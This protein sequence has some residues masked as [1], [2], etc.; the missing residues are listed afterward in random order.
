MK[1]LFIVHGNVQGVGYRWFV[2]KIAFRNNVKGSVRNMEDGSV[3]IIAM[4]EKEAMEKFEKGIKVDSTNGPS[5]M[6]I[7]KYPES[8]EEFTECADYG[9][10]KIEK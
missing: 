4:A 10:F 8:S 1:M 2:K 9:D 3:R 7:E 5:V 6:H